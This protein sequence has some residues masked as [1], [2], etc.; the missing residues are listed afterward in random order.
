MLFFITNEFCVAMVLL[1][2]DIARVLLY[3]VFCRTAVVSD[4]I[5]TFCI[6]SFFL[7]DR[8]PV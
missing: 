3:F 4:P 6:A 1:V 2:Q 5:L 8:R 7:S